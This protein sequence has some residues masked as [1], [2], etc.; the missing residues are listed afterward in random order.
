MMHEAWLGPEG[1]TTGNTSQTRAG[2][3]HLRG[4]DPECGEVPQPVRYRG[5]GHRGVGFGG[6]DIP[7]G[8]NESSCKTKTTQEDCV[9]QATAVVM[10]AAWCPSQ[11]QSSIQNGFTSIT[12]S[13]CAAAWSSES[14]N[15]DHE[16]QALYTYD[17]A[18]AV[19]GPCSP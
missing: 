19:H 15:T 4:K 16:H 13:A 9:K 12:N 11:C 6:T 17:T 14:Q 3:Q 8:C 1:S 18:E 10:I 7:C 2:H 5:P